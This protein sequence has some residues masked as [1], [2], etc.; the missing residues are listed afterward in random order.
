[1]GI[2]TLNKR[3]SQLGGG[4]GGGGEL[5]P[6]ERA[7]GGGATGGP[8]SPAHE[9]DEGRLKTPRDKGT[10]LNMLERLTGSVSRRL[11]NR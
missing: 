9:S 3:K 11:K 6:G 8:G 2:D 1:M 7:S 10:L 5:G 4:G